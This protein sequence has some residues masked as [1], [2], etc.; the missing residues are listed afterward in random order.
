MEV[1]AVKGSKHENHDRNYALFSDLMETHE[2]EE[3]LFDAISDWSTGLIDEN[4]MYYKVVF[5][6]KDDNL[7]YYLI[8]YVTRCQEVCALRCCCCRCQVPLT[9][10]ITSFH[11]YVGISVV[12]DIY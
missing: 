12:Q 6:A 9:T 1:V 8:I 7:T 2:G 3:N 10:C 4:K 5:P 11:S